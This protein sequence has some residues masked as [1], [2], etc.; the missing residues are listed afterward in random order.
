VFQTVRAKYG[1]ATSADDEALA[2]AANAYWVAFAKSGDPSVVGLPKW[3]AYSAK[4][5]RILEF[6]SAGPVAKAD[7]W[8][9][10]LD[11]VERFAAGAPP[12]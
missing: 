2:D 12:R 7:P 6:T 9:T 8:R 11:L 1:D 5:D 3:P 10:R 4:D